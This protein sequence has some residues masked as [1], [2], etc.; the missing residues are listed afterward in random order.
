MNKFSRTISRAGLP[1][2]FAKG[3]S[4]AELA[5]I[6][7]SLLTIL[8]AGTDFGRLFITNI[9]LTNAARAGAAYGSQ[10]A[11]TA[12]DSSGMANAASLDASNVQGFSASASQCTC[13]S[14]SNVTA[15]ATAYC[16]NNPGSSY[17]QVTT[18][19]VFNTVISWPGIPSSTTLTS[20]AIMQVQK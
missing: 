13:Q 15:C 11:A 19:A 4:I 6:V 7:P 9:A 18:Q 5:L 8:L 3:Q 16:S 12:A 2:R 1:R 10:N 14:S 20:N 17:V